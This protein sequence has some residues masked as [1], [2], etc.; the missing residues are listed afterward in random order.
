MGDTDHAGYI[1]AD[2][3]S[4]PAVADRAPA[5]HAGP[6][7]ADATDDAGH[8][9][10]VGAADDAAGAGARGRLPGDR[11]DDRPD[12]RT[13]GASTAL[14]PELN[15]LAAHLDDLDELP[16]GDHVARFDAVHSELQDAL[17]SI[18]E[19]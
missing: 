10:E 19:V 17:A 11:P 9:G 2:A 15:R 6:D 14:S 3:G 5:T 8:T 13:F 4:G 1:P 18:D 12:D 7:E 16:V